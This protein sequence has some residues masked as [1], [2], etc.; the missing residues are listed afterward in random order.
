MVSRPQRTDEATAPPDSLPEGQLSDFAEKLP[1]AAANS[2]AVDASKK[3]GSAVAI[4][5]LI[6]SAVA[7]FGWL[8]GLGWAAI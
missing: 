2:N 8:T 3:K 6:V 1:V 7:M 5:F 4:T